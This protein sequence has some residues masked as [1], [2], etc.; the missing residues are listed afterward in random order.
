MTLKFE[1][2]LQLNHKF[3]EYV[4]ISSTRPYP[5]LSLNLAV[6]HE[7]TAAGVYA[8][9]LEQSHS[10]SYSHNYYHHMTNVVELL[11]MHLMT[12]FSCFCVIALLLGLSHGLV[13]DF[14][15][16]YVSSC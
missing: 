14:G 4:L 13:L 9:C 7:I 11:L 1:K 8:S 3:K 16:C 10:H 2:S 12:E 5:A 6:Y 15:C